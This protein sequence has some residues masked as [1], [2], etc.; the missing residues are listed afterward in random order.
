MT[1]GF[2]NDPSPEQVGSD[3]KRQTIV[4]IIHLGSPFPIVNFYAEIYSLS[5]LLTENRARRRRFEI[6]NL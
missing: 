2:Y 6:P 5:P 4:N 3:L 1:G